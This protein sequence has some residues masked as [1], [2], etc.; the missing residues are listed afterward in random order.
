MLA[1]SVFGCLLLAPIIVLGISFHLDTPSPCKYRTAASC[2]SLDTIAG[3]GAVMRGVGIFLAGLAIVFGCALLIRSRPRWAVALGLP[4]IAFGSSLW[5][6]WFSQ[7]I[8]DEYLLAPW[9]FATSLPGDFDGRVDLMVKLAQH[10]EVWSI[11]S[12]F[13]AA[14]IA[15][16]GAMIARGGNGRNV[17]AVPLAPAM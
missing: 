13:L 14:A 15:I 17:G 10:Y 5:L 11:G 3:A 6:L 7:R 8:L 1:L 4:I 9:N 12:V 2:A 16:A